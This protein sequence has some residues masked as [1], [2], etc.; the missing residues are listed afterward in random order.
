MEKAVNTAIVI[1]HHSPLFDA[2]DLLQM[3]AEKWLTLVAKWDGRNPDRFERYLFRCCVNH[4]FDHIRKVAKDIARWAPEA[5][6]LKLVADDQGAHEAP[7]DMAVVR[8]LEPE[9]RQLVM[10]ALDL[11]EQEDGSV[12][13]RESVRIRRRFCLPSTIPKQE[14]RRLRA[15]MKAVI[16]TGG[17]IASA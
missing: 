10:R 3:C 2:D 7:I 16:T 8:T 14:R 1:G 17:N 9:A 5:A 6:A 12:V 13:G 15:S 4:C 11:K